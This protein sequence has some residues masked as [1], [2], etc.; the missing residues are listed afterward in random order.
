[1][2]Q[3]LQVPFI[4][5]ALNNSV[6]S[7]DG[8]STRNTYDLSFLDL[9]K[10]YVLVLKENILVQAERSGLVSSDFAK[11]G[12]HWALNYPKLNVTLQVPSGTVFTILE[13]GHAKGIAQ[14]VLGGCHSGWEAFPNPELIGFPESEL[15][16]VSKRVDAKVN[17]DGIFCSATGLFRRYF[18]RRHSDFAWAL[19]QAKN[20][21]GSE[22]NVILES[23]RGY[24]N[25]SQ[26][27]KFEVPSLRSLET[28]F[29]I[30]SA[31]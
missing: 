20:E 1:M 2:K 11:E 3:L 19:L 13:I 21:H 28:I 22:L 15:L 18:E 4:L 29:D 31:N 7:F 9:P 26:S 27:A 30:R 14:E 17:A 24:F 10:N 6:F 5:L 25:D 23:F 12:E 16:F 8:E